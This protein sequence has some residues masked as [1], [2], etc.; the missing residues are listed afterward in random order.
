MAS[1]DRSV[2]SQKFGAEIEYYEYHLLAS[3][4]DGTFNAK[5]AL[6]IKDRLDQLL[7]VIGVLV[8]EELD[9]DQSDD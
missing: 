6:R 9:H 3:V 8:S 1:F 4:D 2:D 5:E 7:E